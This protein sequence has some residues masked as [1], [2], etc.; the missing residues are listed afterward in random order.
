MASRSNVFIG[1][2]G[3][4]LG[5][6]L[7]AATRGLRLVVV[8]FTAGLFAHAAE[9]TPLLQAHAHNDYAHARPLFDALQRGF[10]NIEADIWLIDGRLLVAHDRR[11]ARPTQT[12]EELYLDPL[13]ERVRGTGG[14][15]YQ[16][17]PT[18]TLLVDIKSEAAPAYAA[19]HRVLERYAPMLT[20]FRGGG[21][22]PGAVTVI[23][24]GN[25]D[26]QQMAAQP[27]RY[28]ALDGRG[29]HLEA[30]VPPT[31]V[32]WVSENWEKIFTWRGQGA[33]PPVEMA[34]LRHW[35]DR[36]HQ[37]GRK[38]RFWNT[39]DTPDAWAVLCAAGVDII[40]ADNLEALRGFLLART[41]P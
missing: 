10:C 21:T 29:E 28:A 3:S 14:R 35:V 23:V 31:L 41:Q 19:L 30:A 17:G 20:V 7:L 33:M 9:V 40:G 26:R 12:L 25:R 18:V 36:A 39:P 2:G 16:N 1:V 22:K 5:W 27:V 38:V 4:S 6:R 13:R 8:V 11:D 32:P 15:V 37:H 34:L 24:S